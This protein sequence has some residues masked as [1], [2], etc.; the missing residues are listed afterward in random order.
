MSSPQRRRALF[1]PAVLIAVGVG[2]AVSLVR[3]FI[4]AL[5][6]EQ[7]EWLTWV[8]LA[9]QAIV[10]V[11]LIVYLVRFVRNQRDDYWR[12]RGQDPRNPGISRWPQLSPGPLVVG[13]AS[14]LRATPARLCP[15][16]LTSLC[17]VGRGAVWSAGR[18]ARRRA[19]VP[20]L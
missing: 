11:I 16:Q 14:C 12:E 20:R 8:L 9:I 19:R 18:A 6:T 7:W 10:L 15:R 17:R 3:T 13:R 5:R 2:A 1:P 4:P